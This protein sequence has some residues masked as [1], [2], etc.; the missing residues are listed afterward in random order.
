MG[1]KPQT[2]GEP[3]VATVVSLGSKWC[4]WRPASRQEDGT[5]GTKRP[6]A[7]LLGRGLAMQYAG[8]VVRRVRHRLAEGA[9]LLIR[10]YFPFL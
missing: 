1:K 10:P 9:V 3:D 7:E 4:A 6:V 2:P 8:R 5:R